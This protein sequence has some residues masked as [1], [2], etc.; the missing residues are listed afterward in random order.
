MPV[1]GSKERIVGLH[2]ENGR[3]PLCCINLRLIHVGDI[4]RKQL[5]TCDGGRRGMMEFGH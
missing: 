4:L 1:K 2:T 3:L 5:L